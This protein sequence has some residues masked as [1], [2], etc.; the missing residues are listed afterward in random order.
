VL[1]A[2]LA[3]LAAV[4]DSAGAHALALDTLLAAVPLAAVA[5]LAAFGEHLDRRE[6]AV[7]SLQA[8]LWAIAVVLLVLSCAV[9][10]SALHGSVPPLAESAL[11][12]ALLVFGVKLAV[13]AAPLARR[14]ALR[15]A[16]P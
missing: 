9:R 8:L 5:A 14:L 1:P 7:V 12:A 15:P 6:D 11:A 16:K 10:S 2:L 4:A 3:L 13:A